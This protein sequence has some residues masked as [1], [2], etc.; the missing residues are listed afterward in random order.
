MRQYQ[1]VYL[2]ITN[3]CNLHCSFCPGTSRA[4]R[5]MSPEEFAALAQKLR[6]VTRH[7][8]FHLMGEPLLHPALPELL[9]TADALD[10]RVNITTNG[11][12]LPQ[13]SKLLAAAPAVRKVSISLH[14]QEASADRR[15]EGYL[16]HC[17]DFARQ[18]A[19]GGKIIGLRLWNLERGQFDPDGQNAP[20]TERLR[21]AFP[22]EWVPVREGFRLAERIFLEYGERF[23]WPDWEQ[24]AAGGQA[25][26]YGLRDQF[27]VLC[28]GT[29][30]PCCLDH[31]GDLALG[32]LFDRP[33][34]EILS[35]P[36]ATAI[37]EGFSRRRAAE[38]LCRRCG[39]AR[40]F[41]R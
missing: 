41:L 33:L 17:I 7:L 11:T 2:E 12:L 32:N 27:G 37:Y 22:G 29:V 9:Q 3:R 14:S 31:D 36:R 28:D 16:E 30:V 34:E 8:Y 21:R 6:P 35:S 5:T 26:C 13:R 1:K 38:D 40:R 23:T 10:F 24:E 18:A 20:V 4:P 25:F 39:Y 19:V 15:W